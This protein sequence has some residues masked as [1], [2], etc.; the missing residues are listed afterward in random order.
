MMNK[1]L[2]IFITLISCFSVFAQNNNTDIKIS[3]RKELTPK[4]VNINSED[5]V[6]LDSIDLL[7]DSPTDLIQ[8][9]LNAYNSR[10]IDSFLEFYDDNVEAY[11]QSTNKLAFKGKEAM[12]KIYSELFKNT[13]NLHCELINRIVQG[14]TVIDKERVQFGEDIIE[15]VAIYS[16]E[17]KK[18]KKIYFVN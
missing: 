10:N 9:Q 11:V 12:R 17:N 13:P 3:K 15:V 5:V 16:I 8:G 18:I 1:Y 7:S 4:K 2:L 6:K 14:N